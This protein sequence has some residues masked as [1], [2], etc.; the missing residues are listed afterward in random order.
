MQYFITISSKTCK[1][2][3]APVTKVHKNNPLFLTDAT[4][5]RT[6]YYCNNSTKEEFNHD[7]GTKINW[8][9]IG[10]CFFDVYGR[11]CSVLLEQKHILMTDTL[12][13][14]SLET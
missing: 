6:V 11:N 10:H 7:E 4:I 2:D 8:L 13:K 3:R 14:Y 1:R 9:Y 5:D 12:E